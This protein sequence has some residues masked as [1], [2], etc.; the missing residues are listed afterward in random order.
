MRQRCKSNYVAESL[1]DKIV[2]GALWV[3]FGRV[4]YYL[5]AFASNIVL[6]RLLPPSDFGKV[7]IALFFV[8]LAAVIAESGFGGALIKSNTATDLDFSTA[9]TVN[10]ALSAIISAVIVICSESIANFFGDAELRPVL[11]FLSLAQMLSAFYLVQV[12]RLTRSMRFR[13]KAIYDVIAIGASSAVSI[14]LALNGA[15]IWSLV[16]MQPM[17]IT[18]TTLLLWGF[19]RRLPLFRFSLHSFKAY[20]RFGLNT[21][22]TT[23]LSSISASANQVV[24]GKYFS[25]SQA[26]LYFQAGKLQE[27]PVGLVNN[28]YQNVVYSGLAKVQ[29]D[30]SKFS[31]FY[32]TLVRVFTS[33]LGA[34]CMVCVVFSREIVVL[35]FGPA[36]ADA[37][38]FLQVLAIANF[39]YIQEIFVRNVLKIYDQTSVILHVEMF[40]T[41]INA[42]GLISGVAL[43]RL[44]VVVFGYLVACIFSA[45]V[46]IYMVNRLN[47][48]LKLNQ[49]SVVLKVTTLVG[50]LTWA[51]RSSDVQGRS[52]AD[53]IA[54]GLFAGA[55]Y[56]AGLFFLKLLTR[57][58]LARALTVLSRTV[59]GRA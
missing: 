49:F 18:I 47:P 9:F 23:L 19:E 50:V 16:V 35:L 39:F 2:S 41:S 46:N 36:W 30:A 8:S 44:D 28:I 38:F 32:S 45:L 54:M 27:V 12:N 6:A 59:G 56:L 55:L 37:A 26:G 29:D 20:Y 33:F 1:K 53:I 13:A 34:M 51:F 4:G 10:F 3:T 48:S 42:I 52:L 5:I 57:D 21:T 24:I 11:I 17:T 15:G 58:D 14:L 40:K 43:E 31:V 7:A 22:L 25:M